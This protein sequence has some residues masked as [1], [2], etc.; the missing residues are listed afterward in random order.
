MQLWIMHYVIVHVGCPSNP[1]QFTST[2][3]VSLKDATLVWDEPH[4]MD[5]RIANPRYAL[6]SMCD[7]EAIQTLQRK[8]WISPLTPSMDCQ[9]AHNALCLW[10]CTADIV[11]E[12]LRDHWWT[13]SP[14][15]LQPVSGQYC[16]LTIRRM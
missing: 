9:K 6:Y 5:S 16:L 12:T 14:S 1:P 7:G 11:L 3:Y 15:P 4:I 13:V 8:S 10:S 2:T